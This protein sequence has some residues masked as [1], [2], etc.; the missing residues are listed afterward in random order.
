MW[1][2]VIS[3]GQK[4]G[5][6]ARYEAKA[7]DRRNCFPSVAR[8]KLGSSASPS[9]IALGPLVQQIVLRACAW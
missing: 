1:E 5:L 3:L 2:R 4:L 7:V 8:G 6:Q 9:G